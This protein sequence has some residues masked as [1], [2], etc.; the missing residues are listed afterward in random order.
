MKVKDV[1]SSPVI[2]CSED[3]TVEKAA[4]LIKEHQIG[5][6]VVTRDDEPVGIITGR[7][8]AIKVM[9]KDLDASKVQVRDAMSSDIVTIDADAD[10]DEATRIFGTKQLRRILVT[11]NGKLVGILTARELFTRKP[12]TAKLF[13]ACIPFKAAT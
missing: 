6:V 1:M 2:T 10:L 3:E 8:M 13:A 9:A 4:R 12:K 11:E 7:D 5:A